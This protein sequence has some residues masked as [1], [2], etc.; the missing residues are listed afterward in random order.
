MIVVGVSASLGG[1]ASH[2]SGPVIVTRSDVVPRALARR[3]REELA[4]YYARTAGAADA[5]AT[6]SV[7]ARL[8]DRSYVLASIRTRA[9][10]AHWTAARAREELDRA[11]RYYVT[12]RLSF[13]VEVEASVEGEGMT[14]RLQDIAAWQWTLRV[15]SGE[16]LVATEAVTT[17]RRVWREQAGGG[18]YQG[19]TFVP[20]PIYVIEHH[21]VRGVVRFGP[22]KP[23]A[24]RSLALRAYPPG[25]PAVLRV[26]WRLQRS[27]DGA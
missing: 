8:L 6:V 23:D 11:L 3:S 16:P 20:E 18:Y 9:R 15:D 22:P 26:R 2:A 24:R 7:L 21:M 4:A 10:N 1:C 12:D 14:R 17:R 25:I 13:E 5:G 27:P 19:R